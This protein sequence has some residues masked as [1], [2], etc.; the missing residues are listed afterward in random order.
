MNLNIQYA[1]V[2]RVNEITYMVKS[3]D[4]VNHTFVLVPM[5]GTGEEIKISQNIIITTE[6][7]KATTGLKT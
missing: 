3:T 2:F 7:E 5:T 1:D 6:V 4:S